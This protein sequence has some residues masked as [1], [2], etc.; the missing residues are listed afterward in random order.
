MKKLLSLL[1]VLVMGFGVYYWYSSQGFNGISDLIPT[2]QNVAQLLPKLPEA[3]PNEIQEQPAQKAVIGEIKKPE[4]AGD[5]QEAI[6]YEKT[7]NKD[8]VG[9]LRIP[10]ST[11]NHSI[12]QSNNNAYYL[13]L[14]T[15]RNYSV[16]GSLYVDYECSVGT[17]EEMSVNTIIYGHSDLKDNPDGLM[18][19]QLFKF[20]DEDYARATPY[21]Y[22]SSAKDEMVWEVF[23]VS[24]T[25]TSME[26]IYPF[27]EAKELEELVNEAK[28]RSI[29]DYGVEV[30]PQDKILTL[31][32]CTVKYG[33]SEDQRLI[34]MA[35]LLPPETELKVEAKLTVNPDPRQPSL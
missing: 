9:W 7:Q 1:L 29:F 32:T 27:I 3:A 10:G 31:S 12:V 8:T 35:K 6:A 16:F 21:I 15:R 11:I 22:F 34:V 20:I 14:D 18:F 19:S 24:Y 28:D 2:N 30:G 33:T 25:D 5:T 26:Y 17:R 13:K 4:T 23:A